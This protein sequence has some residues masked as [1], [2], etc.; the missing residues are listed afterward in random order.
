MA[1]VLLAASK[2]FG[3][4][5]RRLL[6]LLLPMLAVLLARLLLEG[7]RGMMTLETE[8]VK[9]ESSWGCPVGAHGLLRRAGRELCVGVCKLGL[10]VHTLVWKSR[11]QGTGHPAAAVL[12]ILPVP[13]S[14]MTGPQ[15]MRPKQ[16][17]CRLMPW[18]GRC[19]RGPNLA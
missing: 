8:V 7:M 18:V 12:Q 17:S 5:R 4:M 2:G 15:S 1:S 14:S 9:G 10:G 3:P 13:G 11:R 6:R 19:M 16:S